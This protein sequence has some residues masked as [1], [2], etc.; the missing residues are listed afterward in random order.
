M[1]SFI[2]NR[3]FERSKIFNGK[4]KHKQIRVTSK[5]LKWSIIVLFFSVSAFSQL[6]LLPKAE[7]LGRRDRD[8]R[9]KRCGRWARALLLSSLWLRLWLGQ[10]HVKARAPRAPNLIFCWYFEHEAQILRKF[11]IENLMAIIMLKKHSREWRWGPFLKIV[12]GP[13]LSLDGSELC[14]YLILNLIFFKLQNEE[15]DDAI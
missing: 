7:R 10:C 11:C 14:M 5:C 4:T 12:Q 2:S 3:I 6:H 13:Y 1:C 8:V 15:L 9:Q